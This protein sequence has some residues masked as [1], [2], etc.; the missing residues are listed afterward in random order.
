MI[1][2]VFA[3][4]EGS[5]NAHRE[6][7]HLGEQAY[8][9]PADNFI[10]AIA[11]FE[12]D[13]HRLHISSNWH[14]IIRLAVWRADPKAGDVFLLLRNIGIAAEELHPFRESDIA[15]IF[16]WLYYGKRLDV[17][18]KIC[19]A[20]RANVEKRLKNKEARVHC[21]LTSEDTNRI[22]ASSL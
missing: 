18:R 13:V 9:I 5:K 16:P 19:F 21:H 3:S 22:V 20:A 17:L 4:D 12:G 14:D 7:Y 6:L 2:I 8:V 11:Q 1:E 15:D 10:E